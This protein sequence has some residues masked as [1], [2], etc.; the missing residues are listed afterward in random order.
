VQACV[1][2]PAG[3]TTRQVH[4]GS[5]KQGRARRTFRFATAVCAACPLRPQCTASPRGRT[6][7]VGP[8]EA[9]LVAARAAW[10]E[11]ELRVWHRQRWK[12]ERKIA[13]LVR[14]GLRQARY[15]GQRK[16]HLQARLAA[17]VANLRRLVVLGEF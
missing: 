6:I 2:C 17:T 15:C 7:E 9:E 12:V 3:Q 11:P 1:T 10:A 4:L 14:L 8:Y 5:D 16:L 13:H